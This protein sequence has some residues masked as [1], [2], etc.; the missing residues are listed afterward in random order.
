VE[1][2]QVMQPQQVDNLENTIRGEQ[3]FGSTGMTN[4]LVAIYAIDFMPTAT[5][6]KLCSMV[7]SEY[8]DYLDVFNP[9][10]PMK[11]LPMSCTAYN[12]AIELDPTKPLPKPA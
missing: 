8:H 2:Y 12:F 7:P 1:K 3:G 5:Q 6:E 10:G 4:E 11:Q 9:E